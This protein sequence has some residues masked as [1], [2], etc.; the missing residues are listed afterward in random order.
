MGP[1]ERLPFVVSF[2][3][4]N[5]VIPPE[6]VV[7]NFGESK[8]IAL[9]FQ[10]ECGKKTQTVHYQGG[11]YCRRKH[12]IAF[13]NKLLKH[14][15]QKS[16]TTKLATSLLHA[17]H[18][19]NYVAKEDTA[20]SDPY[21]AGCEW[22]QSIIEGASLAGSR[23]DLVKFVKDCKDGKIAPGSETPLE[24]LHL[25]ARYPRFF[26]KYSCPPARRQKRFV[27][28]LSGPPGSGKSSFP[29]RQFGASAC[30]R[31]HVTPDQRMN[32]YRGQR[33]LVV[34]NFNSSMLRSTSLRTW[35]LQL[36]DEGAISVNAFA[37]S[38]PFAS[39]HIYITTVEDPMY[40][41][42]GDRVARAEFFR[43]IDQTCIYHDHTA[44]ASL[45]GSGDYLDPD[46]PDMEPQF[47]PIVIPYSPPKRARFDRV[48]HGP[49]DTVQLSPSS[50][51]ART[52][53]SEQLVPEF[54][55]RL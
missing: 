50:L 39:T 13:V 10:T 28:I 3:C 33:I 7:E 52:S 1:K 49:P 44:L 23:V 42:S 15:F 43:R 6:K 5:P 24:H 30:F 53:G 19:Y 45:P 47:L 41:L 37:R 14:V 16:C 11:L 48:S 46:A 2:T 55:E 35:F 25:E 36:M 34:E 20:L 27:T 8:T 38:V 9:R 21:E 29:E 4:N 40:W 22:P 17:H 26:E 18:I 31:W 32:G 54:P 51:R 12:S